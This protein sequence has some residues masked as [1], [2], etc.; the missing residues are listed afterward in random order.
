MIELLPAIR[1]ACGTDACS[2]V[3]VRRVEAGKRTT[4]RE[5]GRSWWSRVKESWNGEA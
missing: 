3:R 2:E 1:D 5:G 4:R